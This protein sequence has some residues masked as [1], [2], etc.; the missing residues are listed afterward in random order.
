MAHW[1]KNKLLK[2]EDPSLGSGLSDTCWVGL[3]AGL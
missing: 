2:Y 1:V 3:V